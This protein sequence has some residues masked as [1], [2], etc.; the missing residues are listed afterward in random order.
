MTTGSEHL[1]PVRKRDEVEERGRLIRS[2]LEL[3]SRQPFLDLVAELMN[4][5]PNYRDLLA[6][7]RERPDKWVAAIS[8]AAK[9]AGFADRSEVQHS[10]YVEV[11]QMSD[12]QLLDRLAEMQ[13]LTHA[14]PANRVLEHRKEEPKGQQNGDGAHAENTEVEDAGSHHEPHE[15]KG[16]PQLERQN[17]KRVH[18]I[19][20]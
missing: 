3:Y 11:H 20:L 4:A 15:P 5:A 1:S 9:L 14:P 2:K 6:F 7:A 17:S 19:T 8:Q 13:A 12:S 16:D 10:V 18:R